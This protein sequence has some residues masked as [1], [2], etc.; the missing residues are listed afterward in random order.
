M[1]EDIAAF[2][3]PMTLMVGG[4]LI[5]LGILSFLNLDY[6][7]TKFRSRLALAAGLAFI[8]ATEL[9]FVT[10]SQSGRFLSGQK[11]DV[12]DCELEGETALPLE[13]HKD[14]KILHNRIVACMKKL[15]Y[16]WTAEHDHC[17]EGPIATNPYCYLPERRF[18]R[19]IVMFQTQFE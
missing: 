6:F 4:A 19:T 2:I 8:F 13:R 9:I 14:S 11:I 7:K 3:A 18:A 15:G 12:T 1:N 10:S 16:E 5:A 17:K